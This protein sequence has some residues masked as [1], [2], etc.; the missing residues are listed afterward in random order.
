MVFNSAR[1]QSVFI[2]EECGIFSDF[3]RVEPYE[4]ALARPE[5]PV[6]RTLHVR[7]VQLDMRGGETGGSQDY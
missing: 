1:Y 7:L 4:P 3:L 6:R 5:Q 2:P